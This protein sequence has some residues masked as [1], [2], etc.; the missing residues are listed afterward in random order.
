MSDKRPLYM[1]YHQ[2]R[3]CEEAWK[4]ELL[5]A[6]PHKLHRSIMQT[7]DL[8]VEEKVDWKDDQNDSKAHHMHDLR[9]Q[10]HVMFTSI[11]LLMRQP[12]QREERS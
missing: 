8:D 7:Q 2:K 12:K 3:N 6:S 4:I 5:Y 1:I 10:E 9:K 11:A